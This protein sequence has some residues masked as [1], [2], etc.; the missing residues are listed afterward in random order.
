MKSK[1]TDTYQE[2]AR[3]IGDRKVLYEVVTKKFNIQVALYPGSHIDIAPSIVIPTVTYMDNF[4]GAIRFFNDIDEIEE[5]IEQNKEYLD[6]SEIS[7]LGQDYTTPF[8]IKEVDLI[9]SQYAGFV[10]Q[11]TKQAL[12]TGGILLCNDSHGDAS[13]AKLDEDYEFIGIVNSQKE[14]ETEHLEDYFVLPKEKS[15]DRK[16]VEQKMKGLKYKK[17]AENYLFRKV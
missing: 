14:I 17:N 11:A 3:K 2:Y 8:D 1:A 16:L 12:K 15:I 6:K 7:F 9:I 10:G 5:Y 4:K 13:L